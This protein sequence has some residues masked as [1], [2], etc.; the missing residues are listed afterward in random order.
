M[1]SPLASENVLVSQERVSGFPEQGANLRGSAIASAE[2]REI[3]S[4]ISELTLRSETP[5][6]ALQT[7]YRPTQI[8]SELFPGLQIP[9]GRLGFHFA[10]FFFGGGGVAINL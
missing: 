1:T 2:E 10:T 7:G 3:S 4:P 6:H 9:L 8:L 5:Y